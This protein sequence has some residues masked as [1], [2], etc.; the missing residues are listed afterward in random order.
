MGKSGKS[1]DA[2]TK[3]VVLSQKLTHTGYGVYKGAI[4]VKLESG[5][6]IAISPDNFIPVDWW[7]CPISKA[8]NYSPIIA[9][10]KNNAKSLDREGRWV[11]VKPESTVFCVDKNVP[12]PLTGQD[13]ISC[14]AYTDQPDLYFQPESL[15]VVY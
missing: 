1:V 11:N 10:V 13:L 14:I 6:T 4:I 15:E 9:T 3:F 12:G 7:N 2:K 5:D 8:I